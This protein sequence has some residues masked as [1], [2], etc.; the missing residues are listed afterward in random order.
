MN[1]DV[2]KKCTAEFLGTFAL[3]FFGCGSMILYELNPSAI[4]P[5]AIPIIFGLII[6]VMIYALG[7]ISGAHFNPAV[8]IAF[9][10]N[11]TINTRELFAYIFTQIIAAI[12]ASS[13]HRF[14]FGSDHSFGATINKLGSAQGF[15][16]E[17]LITIFLMLIIISSKL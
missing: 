12:A 11:K 7:H 3:V 9:Y 4:S 8:S 17:V 13:A 14:F 6:A 1:N 5:D 2:I 15:L 16:L 10:Q